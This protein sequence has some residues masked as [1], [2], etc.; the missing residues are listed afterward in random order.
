[1]LG[2][3]TVAVAGWFLVLEEGGE[4]SADFARAEK[5]YV[6]AARSIP[7]AAAQV[8][9]QLEIN[10]FYVVANDAMARMTHARDTFRRLADEEEGDSAR[11][12]DEASRSSSL[13]LS[14]AGIFID[15]LRRNDL[16]D[17][18]GARSQLEDATADLEATATR[19]KQL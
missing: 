18:A 12:A 3:I 5:A 13:G 2:V 4:P 19:W 10:D 11:F 17:A 9:R 6:E 8:Q 15:A 16:S 1:V 14:A 7:A